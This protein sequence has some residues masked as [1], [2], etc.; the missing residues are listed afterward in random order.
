M[1]LTGADV[2]CDRALR[3]RAHF[4]DGT[5]GLFRGRDADKDQTYALALVP[6]AAL[7]RARRSARSPKSEVRAHTHSASGSWVGQGR[8]PGPVL[9][10]RRR[11]RGLH[12]G[13]ARR[14]ARHRAR[15]LRDASGAALGRH[16]GVI[17]YTVGKVRDLGLA[18][19]SRGTCSRSTR[20][21]PSR[22]GGATSS[23]PRGF[24]TDRMNWFHGH[25]ARRRRAAARAHPL[26]TTRARWRPP[27]PVATPR[28]ARSK[29]CSTPTTPQ[30]AVTPG[31]LAVFYDGDR[32]LGGASIFAA[33]R[34]SG[35][36]A[37]TTSGNWMPGAH[38]ESHGVSEK[39]QTHDRDRPPAAPRSPESRSR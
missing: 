20:R 21:R 14:D 7:A 17:H 35:T 37:G 13:Q 18:S 5:A 36:P 23:S 27:P 9:R 4:E 30:S 19:M 28:T 1:E 39:L 15:R 32:C 26:Q 3:A 2:L 8:E 31:Q 34:A 25:A 12:H 24:V 11:P 6:H 33:L 22:S 38:L 10:A 29:R 16:R